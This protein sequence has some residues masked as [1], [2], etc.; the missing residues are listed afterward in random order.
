MTSTA[1]PVADAA[2]ARLRTAVDM[3]AVW[4]ITREE[5]WHLLAVAE[6]DGGYGGSLA[7]LAAVVRA[8]AAAG[9]SAP[10]PELYAGALGGAVGV[11]LPIGPGEALTPWGRW[12]ADVLVLDG[13]DAVVPVRDLREGWNIAG[14]PVDEMAVPASGQAGGSVLARWRVLH[15]ARLA[16]AIEAAVG[17]TASYAETRVQ[18]GRPIARFQ[19]VASLVAE[20]HAQSVLTAAVLDRALTE[21]DDPA[22][23]LSAH[24]VAARAAGVVARIAHQVHG[25]I[26]VTQELGLERLTRRLWAWRDL[27]QPEFAV[28]RVLTAGVAARG[29]DYF[30]SAD[31]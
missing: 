9:L 8:I 24:A 15:T 30:W 1:D 3:A 6:T 4:R 14:E 7:D 20:A 17:R 16:G 29:E 5:Q 19:A 11:A 26:G 23:V 13:S 2:V 10:V 25:A 12:C 31:G 18:F 28:E 22:S 27:W 21:T